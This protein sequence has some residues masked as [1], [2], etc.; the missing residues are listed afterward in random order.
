MIKVHNDKCVGCG[1][2]VKV[3]PVAAISLTNKKAIVDANK[4]TLCSAC[5]TACKFNALQLVRQE[6]KRADISGYKGV[7]VYGEQRDGVVCTV[8]YELLNKARELARDL[9][10]YVGVIFLGHGIEDKAKEL[11]ARG[12]DKVFLVDAPQLKN[13]LAENYAKT[14]INL[15]RKHKPEIVLA[16]ATTTGRS[17]VSR[18]AV[19]LYA[20]LTADCTELH[21]DKDKNILVQTRPA[22][23]GNIMAQIIS[24]IF[25]PQM[26]TVRHTRPAKADPTRGRIARVVDL[27][28]ING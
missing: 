5:V 18:I 27:G 16:G 23:G 17:L 22:F 2:C 15:V 9:N 1:L 20:G 8:V 11:I 25:R 21:I 13:F 4:C 7:W 12:A 19:P 6:I 3:C 28:K 24:P 14:V 10:T 26:A